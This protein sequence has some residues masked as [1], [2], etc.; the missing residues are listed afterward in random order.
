MNRQDEIDLVVKRFRFEPDKLKMIIDGEK[1]YAK[2]YEKWTKYDAGVLS[3][4]MST[5]K[6]LTIKKLF[7]EKI[8][9]FLV[10]VFF[11]YNEVNKLFSEKSIVSGENGIGLV[12]SFLSIFLVFILMP[13]L[14]IIK[15]YDFYFRT[16]SFSD[17]RSDAFQLKFLYGMVYT[18][19]M[20]LIILEIMDM[21]L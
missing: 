11:F 1:L 6:V 7:V 4:A 10:W 14:A 21:V 17:L 2:H 12:K 13:I 15:I 19:I 3:E 18:W 5:I 20:L 16:D 9:P 8:I